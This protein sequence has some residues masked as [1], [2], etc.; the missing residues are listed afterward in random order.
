[1][2]FELSL[3]CPFVRHKVN[4]IT[5]D[6]PATHHEESIQS[7]DVPRVELGRLTEVAAGNLHV[8]E[9]ALQDTHSG[10]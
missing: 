4:I 6:T 7:T 5:P 8:V 9:A 10:Q 3:C 2:R 1:M